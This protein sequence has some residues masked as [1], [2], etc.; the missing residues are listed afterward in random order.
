M[1]AAMSVECLYTFG[2]AAL[3]LGC[4]HSLVTF[5]VTA[6]EVPHVGVG[7]Q[8]L[9]DESGLRALRAA[10]DDYRHKARRPPSLPS[11]ESCR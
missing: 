2:D 3:E 8:K 11:R 5:L 7:R 4:H 6:Y 9:L 1:P 10:Y